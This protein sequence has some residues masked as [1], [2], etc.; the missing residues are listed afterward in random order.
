MY[1]SIFL[2]VFTSFLLLSC[3]NDSTRD[4]IA[5]DLNET[6]TYNEHIKPIIDANCI[7]CHN[8]PPINGAP[9]SLLTYQ[10]VKL[11][12][13]EMELISR[14]SLPEGNSLLMPVG[15]PR[16]PQPLIDV[17]EKWLEDGLQE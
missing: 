17:L 11:A 10:E 1:K 13:Q 2:P 15:G 9:M 4:L 5:V 7:S 12:T 16:L 8:Q 3:T 14:V 6:I